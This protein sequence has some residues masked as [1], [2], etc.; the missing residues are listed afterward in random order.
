MQITSKQN[1]YGR[2]IYLVSKSKS[3]PEPTNKELLEFCDYCEPLGGDI[4]R[5]YPNQYTVSV[6]TN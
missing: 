6:Y 2:T 3:D 5:V 4:K 1:I